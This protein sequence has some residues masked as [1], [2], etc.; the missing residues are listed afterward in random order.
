MLTSIAILL[1]AMITS[2]NCMYSTRITLKLIHHNSIFPTTAARRTVNTSIQFAE[3]ASNDE[4]DHIRANLVPASQAIYYVNFSIG[5][6][7]VPQLAV[8]DTGSSLLWLKCLPCEPCSPDSET[9]F[10]DSSKSSTFKPKVCDSNCRR[11]NKTT[12]QCEFTIRYA[13]APSSEGILAKEELTFSTWDGGY[14]T[15]PDILFGCCRKTEDLPRESHMTG[16]MGLGAGRDSIVWRVGMPRFSYCIGDAFNP[17]Y[18]YNRLEIGEGAIMEGDSTPFTI[19][20]GQYYVTL[21]RISLGGSDLNIPESAF[22]KT[23]GVESG[24]MIDTGAQNTYLNKDAFEMVEYAVREQLR[25]SKWKRVW[26]EQSGGRV[27]YSGKVVDVA[28]S[29]PQLGIHFAG[30]ADL[31]LDGFGMFLQVNW[32]TFCL[33]FLQPFDL[34][35][36]SCSI[37]ILAQQNY[38]VGFDL[39]DNKVYFQRIACEELD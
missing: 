29:F 8:M 5:Q 3:A 22:K 34:N 10:F 14:K 19:D 39:V 18:D 21:E 2:T 36:Y 26:L 4:N 13:S 6:P 28:Q 17:F 16:V 15:V 37:G 38:N 31:F 24:V 35:D 1:L 32:D 27:C 30:G 12:N 9:Q 25:G 23:P 11:C 33:A 7:P 20:K